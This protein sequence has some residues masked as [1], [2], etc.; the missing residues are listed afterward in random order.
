MLRGGGVLRI[1]R[2]WLTCARVVERAAAPAVLR[3][4][5]DPC[6]SSTDPDAYFGP[7]GLSARQIFEKVQQ[8]RAKEAAPARDQR[9]R[10]QSVDRAK[11]AR[12]RGAASTPHAYDL[13][14]EYEEVWD[15]ERGILKK[16][17]VSKSASQ[18]GA[19]GAPSSSQPRESAR[20]QPPRPALTEEGLAAASSKELRRL[21]TDRSINVS[22]C[23]ERAD[24]LARARAHFL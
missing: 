12:V 1:T 19:R 13:N 23:F 3:D 6:S 22:D 15:A 5:L 11:E 18:D 20:P 14:S 2:R 21:L 10:E 7:G 24:L 4:R 8:A 17:K 16:V 9:R